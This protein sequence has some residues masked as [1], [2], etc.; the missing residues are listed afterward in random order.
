MTFKLVREVQ[1]FRLS[2]Q[3]FALNETD[4]MQYPLVQFD[5]LFKPVKTI[6]HG[7]NGA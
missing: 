1:T 3:R 4:T 5:Y 7:N 6:S 2:K